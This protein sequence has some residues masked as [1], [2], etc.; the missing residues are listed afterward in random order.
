[1][2]ICVVNMGDATKVLKIAKRYGL[3]GG[4]VVIGRGTVKGTLLEFFAIN[5]VRKEIVSMII[6]TA[7]VSE[8]ITGIGKEMSFEKPNYGIAFSYPISEIITEKDTSENS[9]EETGHSGQEDTVMYKIITAIVDK[10]K[11]EDVIEAASKAGARGGTIINARGAGVS[12]VKTFF[13]MEIEPEKE[14]VFIIAKNDVKDKIVD[15]IRSHLKL[16]QHNNGILFVLDLHEV[17]GLHQ[18]NEQSP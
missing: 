10:G 4:N 1:M 13:S 2:I 3:K 18:G 8:A 15:S 7:K 14:E 6:D 11:A 12:Q 17:Y 5:E 9:A 16:D